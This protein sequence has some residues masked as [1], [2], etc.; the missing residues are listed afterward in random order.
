M[1][2]DPRQ[3]GQITLRD[4]WLG[5]SPV[6]YMRRSEGPVMAM[7]LSALT[8]GIRGRRRA[9]HE[10][11]VRGVTCDSRQVQDGY[12]FIA[13]PGSKV[14]GRTF[15]EDALRRGAC[16]VVAQGAVAG[17]DVPQLVVTDAR[18]A[19]AE[20]A[21]RFHGNP[22]LKLN[23]IGITGTKGKST[24]AYLTRAIHQAAGEKV[25]LLGT[26]QYA[27]G[28]RT[29]PAPMTT[30]PADEIQRYFSEMAAGGCKT[31]VMEASSHALDQQRTH[32]VRFAAGIF[33][34]LTHDHLDYHGTKAAYRAAKAR[35]FE[36][37]SDHA[38]AAL[39]GDDPA[40]AHFA[41]RTD[42]HV[43]RYGIDG[44]F[45]VTASIERIT[46]EGT[47]LR[48]RLGTEEFVLRSR[49]V[50]RHNVYNILAAA[51]AAWGM[52]YDREHIRGGLESMAAVPGRLEPVDA[53]QD[54][55]VF[56]DYAHTEDSLRNVLS[57]I[58][59]LT[60]GRLICVFGCGGD[61][62][63]SKRPK[64]GGTADEMSD[65][66][67][68]T[69]DNPRTEDPLEIIRQVESGVR[70]SSKYV[71]EPDR[72][73]AIKLAISMAR[74]GDTVVIAGKGHETYQHVGCEIR[75]FDDR[76]VARAIIEA[77]TRKK[78]A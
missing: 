36:G 62:D 14:D 24:T 32:A 15:V 55:A 7:S 33:T 42:A 77:N 52:G 19:L 63:R 48:M 39:N 25:G 65:F 45:E 57:A 30:P 61:R 12:L 35:L 34:N 9:F 66:F 10:V 23:V 60:P 16:A 46:F 13:I 4:L 3:Y 28:A 58:R 18:M 1:P 40:S 75:P 6:H 69:S 8:D 74:Q 64:M 26:I 54:F 59:P 37:L 31:A 68:V 47:R 21:A 71:T 11:E 73:A 43:I 70:N 78:N 20:A 50:G 49:L 56:V 2:K 41:K 17:I 72:A 38:I 27:L 44:A 53:G 67:I 51:A 22:T 76:S 5:T 29:I